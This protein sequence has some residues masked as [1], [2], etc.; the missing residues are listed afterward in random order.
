MEKLKH[1]DNLFAR[2]VSFHSEFGVNYFKEGKTFTILNS[3]PCTGEKCGLG[4]VVS[5]PKPYNIFY[6]Y[7][8]EDGTFYKATCQFEDMITKGKIRRV[9]GT[10]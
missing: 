10:D 5:C 3:R 1:S 9:K 6:R 4:K 7:K 2:G 8:G